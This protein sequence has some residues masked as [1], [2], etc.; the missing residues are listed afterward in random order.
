VFTGFQLGGLK[1]RDQLGRPR[2]RWVNNIKV[3]LMGTG[4][5]GANLIWLAQD[6]F[7]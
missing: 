3:D 6:R 5:D 4:I 1:G 7:R 2:C